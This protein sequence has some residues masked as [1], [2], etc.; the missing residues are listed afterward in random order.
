MRFRIFL[1]AALL[2]LGT[3][4][5]MADPTGAIKICRRAG[6][7][8]LMDGKEVPIPA[9]SSFT[10]SCD[11]DG[12][13]CRSIVIKTSEPTTMSSDKDL[14]SIVNAKLVQSDGH[15]IKL[16]EPLLAQWSITGFEPEITVAKLF[17]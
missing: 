17:H 10:G 7:V 8:G 9:G 1:A 12:D 13:H 11:K 5:A 16:G 2:T 15:P 14:C 4:A 3:T 6:I